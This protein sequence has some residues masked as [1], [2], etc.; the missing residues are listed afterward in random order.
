MQV[1]STHLQD[2]EWDGGVLT[3]EFR[4]GSVYNYSDVPNG[5]FQELLGAASKSAYFR[6]NIKGRFEYTKVG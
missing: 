6:N 1:E 2:V 4:D 3:I 5:T